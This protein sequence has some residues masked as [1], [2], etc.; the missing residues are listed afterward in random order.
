M[1]HGLPAT[2]TYRP[3]DRHG[4]DIVKFAGDAVTIVWL[5]R[6]SSSVRGDGWVENIQAA[7]TLACACALDLHHLCPYEGIRG[8]SEE[9]SC[10]LDLHMGVGVGE[11]VGIHVGGINDRWE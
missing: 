4:G 10:M 8:D 1:L 2:H 11:M 6:T 3:L 9:E 7:A 5:T